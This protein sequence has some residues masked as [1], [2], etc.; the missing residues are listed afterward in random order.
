MVPGVSGKRSLDPSEDPSARAGT[1]GWESVFTT[2][3][4]LQELL[5]GFADTQA[6]EQ[7][8]ERMAVLPQVVPDRAD[9]VAA[10]E[11]RASLSSEGVRL[12]TID[13]LLAQLCLRHQLTLLTTDLAFNRVADL[14]PLSVVRGGIA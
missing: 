6:R 4:I 9:Y 10:A 5:Q 3:L 2:G 8:L 7:V 13:A 12:G 11:L 1:E 14:T